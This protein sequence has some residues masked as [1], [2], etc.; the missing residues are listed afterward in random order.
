MSND[1]KME[2]NKYNTEY[3]L[4]LCD[5]YFDATITPEEEMLLANFLTTP[6]SNI[7]EFNE[8]KAVMGYMATGRALYCQE[9]SKNS[10]VGIITRWVAAAAIALVVVTAGFLKANRGS[11]GDIYIAYIDGNEYTDKDFVMQQ[12][13]NTMARMSSCAS[14]NAVEEQLGAMFRVTN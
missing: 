7:P 12:M 5:R 2:R 10:R 3:W 13:Y 1:N 9:T 14:N 8:I 4:M 11:E 6:E